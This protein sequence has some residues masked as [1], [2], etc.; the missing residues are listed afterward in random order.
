MRLR[1]RLLVPVLVTGALLPLTVAA[2]A[3]AAGSGEAPDSGLVQMAAITVVTQD[4]DDPD[5]PTDD[6]PWDQDG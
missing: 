3:H 2:S 6:W 5:D 1:L 4:P